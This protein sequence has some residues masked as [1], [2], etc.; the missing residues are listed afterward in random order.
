[1]SPPTT[2]RRYFY[3]KYRGKVT[4]NHDPLTIGRIQAQVPVVSGASETA[5][6]MPSVPYAGDNIGFFFIPPV[7]S[8]VWIEFENG[9]PNHPIWT[10]YF[11]GPGEA[12]G[13]PSLADI[14]IIKTKEI[15]ITL[16]DIQ[17]I[18][19][20]TIETTRGQKITMDG[21]G[22]ELSYGSSKVK[23]TSSDVLVS[24]GA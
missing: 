10:G 4:D 19:G 11:W 20:L 1:M 7:N 15:T 18:G 9:D 5:W 12:P 13:T 16:N 6:A 23:L 3:G 24:G 2:R 8:N 22:I 21:S 14:K 17:G